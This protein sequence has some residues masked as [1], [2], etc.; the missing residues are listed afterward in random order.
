MSVLV[1]PVSKAKEGALPTLSKVHLWKA[2][3]FKTWAKQAV[4]IIRE[5]RKDFVEPGDL[6]W[7]Q[8]AL[9]TIISKKLNMVSII[10][11]LEDQIASELLEKS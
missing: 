10:S 4:A 5:I 1:T 6:G 7:R 9:N 3:D 8:Q 11:S 2:D